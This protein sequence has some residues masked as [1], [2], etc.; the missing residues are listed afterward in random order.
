MGFIL[1]PLTDDGRTPNVTGLL[2]EDERQESKQESKD[3]AEHPIN[4]IY[5]H[6][7]FWDT[8]RIEIEKMRVKNVATLLGKTHLRDPDGQPL[9]LNAIDIDSEQV[10]TIL[11]RLCGPDG[12][13]VYFI[14]EMCKTTFVSKTKKKYGRHI[15]WL[16][17]E[18]H[19]PIGTRHCKHGTEFEIKTDNSLGLITLPPSKHRDD[20]NVR[21]HSIGQDGIK[22]IDKMYDKLLAILDDCLK[23][24]NDKSTTGDKHSGHK[25]KN[26]RDQ[27]T[28][29]QDTEYVEY[30]IQTIAN[31]LEPIYK[32]GHRYS[33][34]T[35]FAGL[36][37]KRN[38]LKEYAGKVIEILASH[39]E[40]RANRLRILE[41]TYNKES[42]LVSGYEYFLSVLENASGD[43]RI[44]IDI[45]RGVLVSIDELTYQNG[46]ADRVTSLTENL[47]KEFEFR[48]MSDTKEL[49]YYD[50]IHGIYVPAGEC[51][52]EAQLELL[53]PEISTHKVQ[54][55]TNKI[56]RRTL[57]NRDEFD[58]NEGI[59][60]V[61]N[62]LLNFHIW[63][64]NDHSPDFLSTI[65]LPIPYN[66]SI[67]CHNILRFLARN[68]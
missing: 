61:K 24:V 52:I 29:S 4:Y 62:G 46:E 22:I 30:V 34:I 7:E 43:H 57:T 44:A 6:P 19:N 39:D 65:Q 2:T 60:N 58:S 59:V 68:S 55:V 12:Q 41:D 35:G 38:L 56:K 1:I 14:D 18:Q 11:C 49:Y 8:Q 51:L 42:K 21:Y 17:H 47:M 23:P 16:S 5:N 31:R 40:E 50:A 63:E 64:L 28:N 33:I 48:T 26:V 32:K 67:K 9:Y 10:F 3:G 20:P 15:F 37:Y 54:E 27:D 13:D 25:E 45:L 36:S 66:P 53:Y